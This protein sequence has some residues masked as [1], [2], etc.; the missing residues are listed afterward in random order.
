MELHAY[1]APYKELTDK[2]AITHRRQV[3]YDH[4]SL[5]HRAGKL[6]ARLHKQALADR[7]RLAKATTAPVTARPESNPARG[8]LTARS[9]ARPEP[10]LRKLA[11]LLLDVARDIQ[12]E[13]QERAA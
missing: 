9:I 11:L 7:D 4:P 13:K 6:Y 3:T 10:D 12:A 8:K 1:F 5:P 2:E